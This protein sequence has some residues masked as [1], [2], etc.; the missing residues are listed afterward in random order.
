MARN[1]K[2]IVS[3]TLNEN[4]EIKKSFHKLHSS[5]EEEYFENLLEVFS[6]IIKEGQ[7][8]E[9]VDLLFEKYY[10]Q[11]LSNLTEQEQ[12][13]GGNKLMNFLGKFGDMFTSPRGKADTASGVWSQIKE[14]GWEAAFGLLGFKGPA[15]KALSAFVADIGITNAASSIFDKKS[16]DT[17]SEQLGKSLIEA[18]ITFII[19]ES[20]TG[21][22]TFAYN[23]LRNQVFARDNFITMGR[24]LGAWICK[25]LHSPDVKNEINKQLSQNTQP[26][27]NNQQN[28]PQTGGVNPQQ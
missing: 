4:Y 8:D 3:E 23:V 9:E 12:V 17:F 25:G 27:Q 13:Q 19:A 22:S 15:V 5:K 10:N 28:N 1:L 21:P 24:T 2:K 16:C 7:T 20:T 6:K 18:L 26:A 11:S 14:Y